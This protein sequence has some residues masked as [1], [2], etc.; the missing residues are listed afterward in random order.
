MSYFSLFSGTDCIFTSLPG[1]FDF[2]FYPFSHGCLSLISNLFGFSFSL[3]HSGYPDLPLHLPGQLSLYRFVFCPFSRL[4]LSLLSKHGLSFSALLCSYFGLFPSPSG[5]LSGP[6]GFFS[7]LF[8]LFAGINL[9]LFLCP[10]SCFSD[11]LG[12]FGLTFSPFS[13]GNLDLFLSL[14]F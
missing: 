1:Y 8:S 9:S 4:L 13:G 2:S 7:L 12:L 14:K 5:S 10:D 3:L 11:F 6:L